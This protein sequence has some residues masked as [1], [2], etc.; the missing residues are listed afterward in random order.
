[1]FRV[2]KYLRNK[3]Y[4]L[5]SINKTIKQVNDFWNLQVYSDS[6][7]EGDIDNHKSITGWIII[8]G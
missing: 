6:D 4:K 1:M 2:I 5:I 8:I 7:W 3:T